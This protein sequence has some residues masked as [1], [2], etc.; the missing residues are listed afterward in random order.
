MINV[1][2]IQIS[3]RVWNCFSHVCLRSCR[4]VSPWLSY[5]FGVVEL[6]WRRMEHFFDQIPR[7][8]AGIPPMLKPATREITSASVEL[9]ETEVCFLHIQ[10]IGTNVCLP[11][12]HRVHPKSILSLQDLQQSQGL[13]TVCIIVL[14]FPHDNIAGI[15]SYSVFREIKRAKRLSHARVH[16]VT[17]EQV[18]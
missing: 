10:L 5:I 18:C 14:Y 13:E 9:C 3:V 4:Q 7:S 1:G 15:H 8:R 6:V 17:H 16:L 2:Q 11:K 12:V